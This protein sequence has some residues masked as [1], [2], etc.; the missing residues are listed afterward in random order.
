MK[1]YDEAELRLLVDAATHF[2][3]GEV[4]CYQRE[5]KLLEGTDPQ[6]EREIVWEVRGLPTGEPSRWVAT[7]AEAI[8]LCL[9]ARDRNGPC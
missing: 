1:G 3:F 5:G 7:K 8:A 9:A 6:G 4:D 2:D